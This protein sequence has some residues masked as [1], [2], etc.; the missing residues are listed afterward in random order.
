[1]PNRL[2]CDQFHYFTILTY[3]SETWTLSKA[4]EHD[5]QCFE[6][7]ILRRIYGPT[8]EDGIWRKRYNH[9]L[10]TLYRNPD[11][12]KWIKISRLRLAGHLMKMKEKEIP[13]RMITLQLGGQRGRG[14]TR[15][16]WID[17]VSG[18]GNDKLEG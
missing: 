5:L 14:I 18:I 1:M 8:C 12:S 13:R 17:G 2:K 11:I 9:E 4:N 15:L 3:A 16:R 7:K 6:R 10:Y